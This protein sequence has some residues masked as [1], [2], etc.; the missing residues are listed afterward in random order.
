MRAQWAAHVEH[1]DLSDA[2]KF[3][4]FAMLLFG[5]ARLE[6]V[7]GLGLKARRG[8]PTS[9][10]VSACYVGGMTWPLADSLDGP[11]LADAP[12]VE[13]WSLF[14]ELAAA[15]V[16][17]AERLRDEP[18]LKRAAAQLFC[19]T[20]TNIPGVCFRAI[21]WPT[22]RRLAKLPVSAGKGGRPRKKSSAETGRPVF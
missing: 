13:D 9:G 14:D 3:K 11:T 22:A 15:A 18:G 17:L 16:A 5:D 1:A 2:D 4:I 20:S 7:P 19:K 12:D 21:V 6:Q 10:G 8:A